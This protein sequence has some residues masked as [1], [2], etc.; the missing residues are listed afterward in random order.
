MYKWHATKKQL[1]KNITIEQ[2]FN[3]GHIK[4][5]KGAL[6]I[7]LNNL[8][9]ESVNQRRKQQITILAKDYSKKWSRNRQFKITDKNKL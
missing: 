9:E 4:Y 6:I 2:P 1:N 8:E 3:N 5:I 7:D